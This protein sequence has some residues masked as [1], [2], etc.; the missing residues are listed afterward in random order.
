MLTAKERKGLALLATVGSMSATTLRQELEL[1]N[2][3]WKGV[4]DYMTAKGHVERRGNRM[5]ITNKGRAAL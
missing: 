1:T 3:Q 4:R 5:T 2:T